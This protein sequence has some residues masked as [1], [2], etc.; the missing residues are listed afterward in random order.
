[1]DVSLVANGIDDKDEVNLI[2]I[3]E[4]ELFDLRMAVSWVCVE[5]NQVG[6][7]VGRNQDGSYNLRSFLAQRG[8]SGDLAH[9]YI[10]EGLGEPGFE[11]DFE[12]GRSG[13]K[14]KS[15]V[16]QLMTEQEV[17]ILSEIQDE[18]ISTRLSDDEVGDD[19][20]VDYL[21]DTWVFED[22]DN[23]ALRVSDARRSRMENLG[24]DEAGFEVH[25]YRRIVDEGED[26]RIQDVLNIWDFELDFANEH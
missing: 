25:W 10:Y 17:A 22:E 2:V 23:G 6:I 9:L 18:L 5:G 3:A 4:G 13:R 12:W 1:M 7:F 11:W 14:E 21:D 15:S 20:S 16:T 24:E 8:E 19:G 26:E